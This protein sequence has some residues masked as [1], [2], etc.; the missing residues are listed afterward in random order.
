MLSVGM[1][2]CEFLPTNFRMPE[3]IFIKLGIMATEPISTA[4]LINS[5]HQSVCVSI[6]LCLATAR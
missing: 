3:P 2:V 1:R 4:Y 5:F 6:Y